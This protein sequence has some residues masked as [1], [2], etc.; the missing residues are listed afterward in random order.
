MRYE[1]QN[2][3]VGFNSVCGAEHHIFQGF[4]PR[5]GSTVVYEAKHRVLSQDRVQQRFVEHIIGTFV[6]MT[7][8]AQAMTTRGEGGGRSAVVVAASSIF[9]VVPPEGAE[10][11]RSLTPR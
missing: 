3:K 2:I 1:E 7:M 8:K 5:Q 10:V 9:F 4:L 11:A 6:E